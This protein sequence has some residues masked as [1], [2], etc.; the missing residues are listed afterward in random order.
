MMNKAIKQ[1]IQRL[2]DRVGVLEKEVY[3]LKN[4][5]KYKVGQT[6][7]YWPFESSHLHGINNY[8]IGTVSD[9][10]HIVTSRYGTY[11][12]A[13]EYTIINEKMVCVSNVTEN[14]II[15]LVHEKF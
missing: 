4:P 14:K 2:K 8:W 6:V 1:E 10:R 3:M 12:Y 9:V 15:D 13:W 11:F 5:A 7:R